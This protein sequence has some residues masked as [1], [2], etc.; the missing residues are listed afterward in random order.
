M[1]K[2]KNK[3][4]INTIEQLIISMEQLMSWYQFNIYVIYFIGTVDRSVAS[5]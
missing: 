4:N 5:I 3:F 2:A 1:R